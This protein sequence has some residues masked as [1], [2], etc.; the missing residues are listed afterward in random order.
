MRYYRV[1]SPSFSPFPLINKWFIFFLFGCFNC[2]A[3]LR[4]SSKI[5]FLN[6][7][8]FQ[9]KL[10]NIQQVD[11]DFVVLV[12][13]ANLCVLTQL[14]ESLQCVWRPNYLL[15][16]YVIFEHLPNWQKKKNTQVKWMYDA[17]MP[18]KKETRQKNHQY[19]F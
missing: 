11:G 13:F 8:K 1:F 12:V 15:L 10:H 7:L 9:F 3:K 16:H 6:H 4:C 18:N 5:I 2:S 19:S 17:L 14:S